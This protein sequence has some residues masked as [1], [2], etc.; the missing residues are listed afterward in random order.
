MAELLIATV[1]PPHELLMHGQSELI[2]VKMSDKTH[3]R[4]LRDV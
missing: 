4:I 3:C 2:Q 1:D